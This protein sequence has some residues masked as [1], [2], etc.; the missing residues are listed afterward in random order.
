MRVQTG[1]VHSC[2]AE[3]S[4][5]AQGRRA[6]AKQGCC[7]RA[8]EGIQPLSAGQQGAAGR[9]GDGRDLGASGEQ[10]GFDAIEGPSTP[11]VQEE[12]DGPRLRYGL[13]STALCSTLLRCA[14][15]LPS[16]SC[17]PP[18]QLCSVVLHPA[19]LCST[20]A[21]VLCSALLCSVLCSVLCFA[22]CSALCFALLRC[23]P[24]LPL[25]CYA[26]SLC[27]LLCSTTAL[28]HC[29]PPCS[30]VLHCHLCAPLPLR[31]TTALC[32]APL[33]PLF[34]PPPL[35]CAAFVLH[36][37]CALLPLCSTVAVV[38][39]HLTPP[40]ATSRSATSRCTRT[41]T[42]SGRR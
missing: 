20:A 9:K 21:F 6:Q 23:A 18:P 35:C 25:V 34:A 41:T 39:R 11:T 15:S 8:N 10:P 2:T 30:I 26:L 22:L 27:A 5:G 13:C 3:A 33:L 28:L 42:Q 4:V 38:L 29:A 36:H 12:G 7:V 37:L 14:S 32:Y 17:A 24:L 16:E 31:S 40:H 1:L 19:L